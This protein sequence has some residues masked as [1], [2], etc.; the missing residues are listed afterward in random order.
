MSL[1]AEQEQNNKFKSDTRQCVILWDNIKTIDDL[2][3]IYK[4]INF[5]TIYLDVKRKDHEILLAKLL[6]KGIV[7]EAKNE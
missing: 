4:A 5:T 3:M 1:F 6:E 2:K 7:K